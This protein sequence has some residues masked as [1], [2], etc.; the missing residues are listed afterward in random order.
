VGHPDASRVRGKGAR[1]SRPIL[2][3]LFLVA[4]VGGATEERLATGPRDSRWAVHLTRPGLPNL[5]R[6]STGLYRGGQP[7]KGGLDSLAQ[8]GVRTVVSLRAFH[9]QRKEVEG[10]GLRYE[11]IG[12]RVW[13][14]EDENMRRFLA[15]ATDPEKQPVFVHCRR[16]ADRTG[17]AVAVYRVCVEGWT[18]EDAIAEMMTGGFHFHY[19]WQH[20]VRYVRDLDTEHVCS[21]ARRGEGESKR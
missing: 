18:K 19:S 16:G 12:F 3:V 9:S 10:R 7:E 5:H 11:R 13:D 1:L 17:V 2:P 20:L 8:L 15:V 14:L 4:A 21:G 6:V